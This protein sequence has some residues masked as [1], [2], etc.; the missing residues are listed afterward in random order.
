M[1]Y[2]IATANFCGLAKGIAD[3]N[4]PNEGRINFPS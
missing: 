4:G 3:R 1:A 2:G